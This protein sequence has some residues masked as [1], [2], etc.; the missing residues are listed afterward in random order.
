MNR[1]I[2]LVLTLIPALVFV[3][4]MLRGNSE[5]PAQ[6][7]L[8]TG[9]STLAPLAAAIAERY[10]ATHPGLRIDVE[11]GGSSRGITDVMRGDADIGMASRALAASETGLRA[12]TVA[13]DGLAMIVNA[14]N[15]IRSISSA[16][17]IA[18]YR[19]RIADW[20][21]L[22]GRPGA[23]ILVHK[24]EGRGTLEVFLHHF[25]LENSDI[26]PDV[27]VGENAQG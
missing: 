21:E 7:L 26:R 20:R 25:G 23:V 14:Q 4:F 8:V 24:A 11:T 27:V 22:G 2:V 9:S 6:R 5:Q 12:Y 17:V 15:P 1:R 16:Q 3:G 10:E 18:L 19:R 13:R